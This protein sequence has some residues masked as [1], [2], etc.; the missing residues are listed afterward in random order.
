MTGELQ[1]GAPLGSDLELRSAPDGSVKITASF[2]YNSPAVLSDGGRNGRP[3]K[4]MILSGAFRYAIEDQTR[5]IAFLIGH[6][7]NRTLASKLAGSLL[8]EDTRDAL[9]ITAIISPLIARTQYAQD[10]IAQ[11]EAGLA[12]GISPGFRLPP[13]RAV[14]RE[15]A[16]SFEDEPVDPDKGMHG[17]LIRKIKEAIL[18]E[19][20]LVARPAYQDARAEL[21]RSAPIHE[22]PSAGLHRAL[23]RWRA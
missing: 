18:V 13:E 5:D 16:E 10:A 15:Q 3:Q 22:P 6:D 1:T 7:W 21:K 4:E 14:P 9:L 11:L 19:L 12:T 17:A 2:R 20:S 23:R 8:L